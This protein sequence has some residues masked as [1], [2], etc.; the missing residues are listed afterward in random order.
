MK[1]SKLVTYLIAGGLCIILLIFLVKVAPRLLIVSRP[2]TAIQTTPIA[3][4]TKST[5]QTVPNVVSVINTPTIAAGSINVAASQE[6]TT[7]IPLCTFNVQAI[8]PSATLPLDAYTFAE[9]QIVLTSATQIE[10]LQWVSETQSLLLLHHPDLSSPQ[11]IIETLNPQTGE[12]RR[13]AEAQLAGTEPFWLAPVQGVVFVERLSDGQQVLRLSHGTEQPILDIALNIPNGAM[14]IDFNRQQ[15]VLLSSASKKQAHM[16]TIS[17]AEPVQT[18]TAIKSE[19][20]DL[21]G[22]Y[23]MT[24]SPDGSQAA[25]YGREGLYVQNRLTGQ[26]CQLSLGQVGNENR[27]GSR[28]QW[29][30]DSQYIALITTY[31]VREGDMLHVMDLTVVD[32]NTG[33]QKQID[34]EGKHAYQIYWLPDTHIFLAVVADEDEPN[35]GFKNLYLVDATT[36]RV[37]AILPD[38][39]FLMNNIGIQWTKEGKA[40]FVSC[41]QFTS[42]QGESDE[43]RICEIAV[44]VPQ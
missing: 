38:H 42:R 34:F 23:G 27:W 36:S 28:T 21:Q 33:Q 39:R 12:R 26:V 17:F 37:K 3:T 2:M 11:D 19:S 30:S 14:D 10:L 25:I 8:P 40:V 24:L 44:K 6:T 41:S 1:V 20:I 13:Y 15:L 22:R 43:W 32:M 4:F 5:P 31:G 18:V 29:S 7:E 16:A 9:P 35:S